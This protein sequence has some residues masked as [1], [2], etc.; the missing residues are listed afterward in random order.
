MFPSSLR[1]R[2]LKHLLCNIT[3]AWQRLTWSALG[4]GFN[5]ALAIGK[6]NSRLDLRA[7]GSK[8]RETI[9]QWEGRIVGY[10]QSNALKLCSF[11]PSK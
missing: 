5:N 8:C 11:Y 9:V 10:S 2:K 4:A 6:V 1:E 7:L 3:N